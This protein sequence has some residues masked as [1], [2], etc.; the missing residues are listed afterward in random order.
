[1]TARED[2][3]R[4]V[5]Q[6]CASFARNLAYYRVGW[7]EEHKHLLFKNDSFWRVANNNCLDICVFEWCK[8]FGKPRGEYY[9]KNLV[10]NPISFRK[11]L[12]LHLGL[13]EKAFSKEVNSIR[14]Y[15]NKWIAHWDL[16]RPVAP[17]LEVPKHAVWFYQPYILK[18]EPVA[19]NIDA[20][21]E[22]FEREADAAYRT[23]GSW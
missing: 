22:E 13:D 19:W 11:G 17:T 14:E 23:A 16:N 18:H 3:L 21:Y 5:L 8:L 9:W 10:T 20:A 15:R 7:S 2:K 6:L 12:L 4:E 1:M